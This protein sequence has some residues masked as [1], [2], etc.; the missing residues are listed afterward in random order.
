[1][2]QDPVPHSRMMDGIAGQASSPA[3][4]GGLAVVE[5][6]ATST[7][8]GGRTGGTPPKAGTL[9][10]L[11]GPKDTIPIVGKSPRK[12]RSSRFHVTERVDLDKLPGFM[13]ES[14]VHTCGINC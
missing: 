12:Q 9:R 6:G 2:P 11:R 8:V 14:R 1:M 13:G 3:S 10:G 7:A 5:A 4:G